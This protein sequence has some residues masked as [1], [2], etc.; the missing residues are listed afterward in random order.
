MFA[1]VCSRSKIL[2]ILKKLIAK[3]VD[4]WFEFL[5]IIF[6]SVSGNVI[7]DLFDA[8][9][10]IHSDIPGLA[11]RSKRPLEFLGLYGTS[12]RACKRHDIPAIKVDWVWLYFHCC[13]KLDERMS[14]RSSI[15]LERLKYFV[16]WLGATEMTALWMKLHRLMGRNVEKTWLNS[17]K[18]LPI[19]LSF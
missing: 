12:H 1:H 9:Q 13:L 2:R 8:T 5:L 7:K 14:Y 17:F 18:L 10:Q 19:Y 16:S 6:L 3:L 4:P 15:F 11:S